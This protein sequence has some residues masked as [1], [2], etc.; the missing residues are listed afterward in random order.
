MNPYASY[1]K[2][3]V[4]NASQEEIMLLLYQGA[5]VRLR[6]AREFWAEGERVKAMER[7]SQAQEIISYLDNTLDMESGGELAEQ[8][9][10]LYAFMI[11]EIN[12]STREFDFERLLTVEEL[13]ESMLE[14]WKDAV[15]EYRQNK[16]TEKNDDD[17]SEGMGRLAVGA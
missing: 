3:Q 11:R 5:I 13:L 2:N 1:A 9:D 14:A 10:A 6:Q 16:S 8:L 15:Q 17:S 12:T 7:R 4:E